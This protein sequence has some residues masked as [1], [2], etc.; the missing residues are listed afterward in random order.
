MRTYINVRQQKVEII[1][2]FTEST[3]EIAYLRISLLKYVN[4]KIKLLKYYSIYSPRDLYIFPNNIFFL[5]MNSITETEINIFNSI[6][7]E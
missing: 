3:N 6:N 4:H 7:S 2:N 1:I 5:I